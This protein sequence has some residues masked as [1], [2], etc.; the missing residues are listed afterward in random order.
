MAGMKVQALIAAV[1]GGILSAAIWYYFFLPPMEMLAIT[2]RRRMPDAWFS[3]L[4]EW[5][6]L[7]FAIAVSLIVGT[8][9]AVFIYKASLSRHAPQLG[10]AGL[11]VLLIIF[12]LSGLHSLNEFLFFAWRI[13][14]DPEGKALYLPDYY[15]HACACTAFAY[16]WIVTVVLI[17]RRRRKPL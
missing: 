5:Y 7:F 2:A 3:S 17:W 4:I 1:L 11:W 9:A 10:R 6:A 16:S 15:F 13:A 8:V 12:S 14:A